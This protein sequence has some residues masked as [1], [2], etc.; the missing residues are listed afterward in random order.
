MKIFKSSL[1]NKHVYF[2]F[3]RSKK[4]IFFKC[5]LTLFYYLKN[6]NF[7]SRFLSIILSLLVRNFFIKK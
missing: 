4:M 7:Q 2:T 6:V 3:F 1:K 5:K